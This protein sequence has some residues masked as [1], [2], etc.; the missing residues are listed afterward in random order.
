M[1]AI[2]T[3]LW[4]GWTVSRWSWSNDDWFYLHEA[5]TS[6]LGQYLTQDYNGH[7]MPGG[8]FITWVFT[9]LAPLDYWL[10]VMFV[11]VASAG[12]VL[13][14]GA[15][16]GRIAG[17]RVITL[18]PLGLVALSSVYL[19]PTIW[20]A[21]ATQCL[22]MLAF[23][24]LGILLA[25]RWRR[26]RSR[27]ELLLL[28]VA[29]ASALLFWQ[30]SVLLVLPIAS[31]LIGVAGQPLL[32]RIASAKA[33]LIA[34][35]VV[36]ALYVPAYLLRTSGS[37]SDNSIEFDDS[38]IQGTGGIEA[39]ARA[40][41]EVISPA[42]LGGPWGTLPVNG[43]PFSHPPVLLSVLLAGTVAVA[44]IAAIARRRHNW[45]PL[46]MAALYAAAAWG[47]ILLS[48]RFVLLREAALTDER[49]NADILAAAVV[50]VALV[51]GSWQVSSAGAHDPERSPR[52]GQ[53]WVP[54]V[55]VLAV[56]VSLVAAN[57]SQL[58]RLDEEPDR[59][60]VDNLLADLEK[61]DSPVTMWDANTPDAVLPSGFYPNEARLSY[62]LA[63]LEPQVRFRAVVD[64]LTMIDGDGRLRGV[65]VAAT[66]QS[67]PG[68]VEGCG[69]SVGDG[70]SVDVP[71][72]SAVFHWDWAMQINAMAGEDS[73]LEV[74]VGE[75]V[76][77]VP[78]TSG[79]NQYQ[80]QVATEVPDR[81]QV[82]SAPGSPRVCVTEVLIG[83]VEP[84][85]D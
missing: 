8:F 39:V 63:P 61:S 41:S 38:A 49:F 57:L 66:S 67:R 77:H 47:M 12:I 24:G 36:T 48:N 58:R 73:T 27:R 43:N 74:T 5:G 29:Y 72:T 65:Q 18:A 69:Y 78:I 15:A 13:V 71:M 52:P 54:T 26:G 9:R 83:N 3:L 79:L 50:A 44:A 59:E 42:L 4:R 64:R 25:E 11:A 60:W 16:L 56:S 34:M 51:M 6:S 70:E 82:S 31:V 32:R 76:T 81:I 19:R 10:P 37:S 46:A 85:E 17:E 2:V 84:V 23:M 62:V 1:L 45:L 21:A 55:V 20:W 68:P 14:W 30:K 22:T 7:L 28:V 33:P 75:S 40:F 35:T 53:R 80:V